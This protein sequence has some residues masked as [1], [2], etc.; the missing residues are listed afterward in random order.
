MEI[1]KINDAFFIK[2]NSRFEKVRLADI[3]WIKAQHNFSEVITKKRRYLV[4]TT[5]SRFEQ[6]VT[7]PFLRVHRS[8]IINLAK[9]TAFENHRL[10]IE[11]QEIPI[12]K[13]NRT[14]F[15]KHISKIQ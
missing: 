1:T 15:L 6:Q 5:L 11:Q 4:A 12:S 13:A 7:Y 3:L 9:M 8:Y 2:K 10:F 14:G